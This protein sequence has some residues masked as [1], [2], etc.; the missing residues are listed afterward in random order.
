MVAGITTSSAGRLAY[1]CGVIRLPS[2]ADLPPTAVVTGAGS[3]L[4]REIALALGARGLA[5]HV[6]DID[7]EAAAR[8][9][10]EIG[11][12][13]WSSTLDVRDPDACLEAARETARRG[14]GG[15]GVWVNNAGIMYTGPAWEHSHEEIA[16]LIDI[17]LIGTINGARAALD[18]MIGQR[19]GHILNVVSLAGVIP[20]PGETV[21]SASKH[22]ALGFSVGLQGDLARAGIP[23]AVSALCPDSM[24][25]PMMDMA[26]RDEA[27]AIS[28]SGKLLPPVEVAGLVLRLLDKPRPIVT[29]PR[30]RGA[31]SWFFAARPRL[32]IA[33]LPIFDKG[34]R[35][36]QR[37][38]RRRFDE[39]AGSGGGASTGSC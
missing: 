34:S 36:M 32:A 37:R 11:E 17:N 1:G 15:L 33:A 27:A 35:I 28:F 29:V 6:T 21:Y 14:P 8:T 23:V 3:G 10:A 22:G 20:V 39:Q 2:L 24:V 30:Y 7:A 18:T 26:S 38:W 31:M 16:R 4:G 25:T 13:S 9:S 5:V 12:P 19:R